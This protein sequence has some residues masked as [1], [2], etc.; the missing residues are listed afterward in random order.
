MF[1]PPASQESEK[2]G[3]KD[4]YKEVIESHEFYEQKMKSREENKGKIRQ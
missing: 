2:L 4:E 3:K 1:H